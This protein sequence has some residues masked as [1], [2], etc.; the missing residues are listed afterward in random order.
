MPAFLAERVHDQQQRADR[1]GAVPRRVKAGKY[2]APAV[3]VVM[4]CARR[5]RA[6]SV[7]DVAEGAAQDEGERDRQ[8]LLAALRAQ[9]HTMSI[10]LTGAR[11]RV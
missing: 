5:S 9:I 11:E 8:Q 4:K 7:D 10:T 1:D 2:A 3:C 6:R